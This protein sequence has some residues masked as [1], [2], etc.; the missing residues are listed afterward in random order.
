MSLPPEIEKVYDMITYDAAKI[1]GCL[2]YTSAVGDLKEVHA[3]EA[4]I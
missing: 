4:G 2:L 1:L 3:V